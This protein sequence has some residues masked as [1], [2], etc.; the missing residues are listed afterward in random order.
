MEKIKNEEESCKVI[1][2]GESAVGKTSLVSRFV[3]G[4]YDDTITCSTSTSYDST[5]ITFEDY[6]ITLNFQLWDTAGQERFRGLTRLFYTNASIVVLVFD[7]TDRRSFE[8]LNNYW[9]NE[10]R[11]NAPKDISKN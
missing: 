6:N 5:S 11:E 10:I 2:V 8:E 4:K 1:L 7:I 3:R 9:R